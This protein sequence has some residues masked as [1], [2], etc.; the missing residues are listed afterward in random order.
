MKTIEEIRHQNLMIIRK[1]C[2]SISKIAEKTGKSYAQVHQWVKRTKSF[3][4]G[5]PRSMSSASARL[6]EE[7]FDKEIGWM[8]SSSD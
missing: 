7:K 4:A 3:K 8:D 5:I 2:G 6:L 1:E